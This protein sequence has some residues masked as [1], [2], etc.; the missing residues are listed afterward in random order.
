MRRAR[1][2]SISS[3]TMGASESGPPGMLPHPRISSRGFVLMPLREVAPDWRHPVS[4]LAV[5]ALII[6]LAPQ[7]R[8]AERLLSER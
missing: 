5:D 7:D 3:I 6:A 8:L 4:G 1:W 2:I